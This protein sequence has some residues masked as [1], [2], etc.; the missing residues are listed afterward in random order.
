MKIEKVIPCICTP[1]AKTVDGT[2]GLPILGLYLKD[3][4]LWYAP[5]CPRCGRGD[6]YKGQ[7][8]PEEALAKW[9]ELQEKIRKNLTA[10][11][12][13]KIQRVGNAMDPRT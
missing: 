3:G 1:E 4:D 9:N 7:K 11:T 6:R 5:C 2:S 8:T 10:E 13:R 12:R